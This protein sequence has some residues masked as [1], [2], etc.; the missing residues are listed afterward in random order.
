M[1]CVAGTRK[2]LRNKRSTIV[3]VG[4][5]VGCGGCCCCCCCCPCGCWLWLWLWLVY[6]N[7]VVSQHFLFDI[8]QELRFKAM[9]EK[10]IPVVPIVD[11]KTSE[12]PIGAMAAIV[13]G[14]HGVNFF[15]LK[16]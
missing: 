13:D 10:V 3:I 11:S 14:S 7:I 1:I 5:I 2:H 15:G 16:T 4:L 6:V 8:A 9:E 12:L